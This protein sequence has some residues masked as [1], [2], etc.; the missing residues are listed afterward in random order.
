MLGLHGAKWGSYAAKL[1]TVGGEA[2]GESGVASDPTL[3]NLDCFLIWHLSIATTRLAILFAI[4]LDDN[5]HSSV[6][7]T[8]QFKDYIP[9]INLRTFIE[10]TAIR[11]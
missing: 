1:H 5:A 11:A 6:S 3:L 4:N 7:Q 10:I 8:H 2:V 9:W